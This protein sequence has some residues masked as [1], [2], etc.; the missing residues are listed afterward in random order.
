MTAQIGDS[1]I[2]GNKEYSLVAAQR[3][4]RFHPEMY[5]IVPTEIST[6]CYRGFYCTYKIKYKKLLLHNLTVKSENGIYPE[7]NG[8]KPAKV[9]SEARIYEMLEREYSGPYQYE[10][11][12]IHT[13]Y[14]GK[15]LLGT[16]FIDKYYIHMGFQRAW[17]YEKLIEIE[18]KRGRVVG[19][20]DYSNYAEVMRKKIE[21]NKEAFDKWERENPHK[22][23]VDSFSLRYED[24]VWW[25]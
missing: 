1:F 7:I 16:G 19:V 5:G 20:T 6:A 12:N 4:I 8:I 3:M 25:K 13:F 11:L 15:I 14:T 10:P 23:V 9:P 24:K 17:A 18:F 2:Y 21:D 22:F